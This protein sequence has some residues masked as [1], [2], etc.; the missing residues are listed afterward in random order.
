MVASVRAR[1]PGGRARRGEALLRPACRLT[2]GC[3]ACRAG[4]RSGALASRGGTSQRRSLCR[5]VVHGPARAARTCHR[6]HVRP[7]ADRQPARCAGARGLSDIVRDLPAAPA[8][9]R[10][11]AERPRPG[12]VRLIGRYATG[13][14]RGELACTMT[15]AAAARS[16]ACDGGSVR[17]P[18]RG[19]A[20]PC[21][22]RGHRHVSMPRRPP[23]LIRRRLR[24]GLAAWRAPRPAAPRHGVRERP[25]CT[26]PA[27]RVSTSV[28]GR[29]AGNRVT[30]TGSADQILSPISAWRACRR[31]VT[32]TR[33][34]RRPAGLA[35]PAA[36]VRRSS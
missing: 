6:R 1:R 29:R 30:V 22:A 15:D 5:E 26:P 4:S 10:P 19:A 35:C 18:R 36:G 23:R 27:M 20:A 3:P 32:C 16:R 31:T 9:R 28:A 21:R 13:S 2:S 8:S 11:R 17:V 24:V 34:W 12:R 7:S 25:S 14:S 33:C